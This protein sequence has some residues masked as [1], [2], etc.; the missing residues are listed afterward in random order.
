MAQQ[1]RGKL[2]LLTKSDAVDGLLDLAHGGRTVLSWSLNAESVCATWEAGTA[3]L[4]GRLA[5]ARRA[6]EAGY[7]VRFVYMPLIPVP[8]WRA[9]YAELVA[10]SLAA[11]TPSR[12]TLGGICSFPTAARVQRQ[13]FGTVE[14]LEQHWRPTGR[15][16]WRY[17]AEL[18]AEM[19]R[20]LAQE[21]RRRRP[22]LPLAL[23]LETAD[24]WEA[25][26]WPTTPVRCNCVL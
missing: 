4:D 8:D 19:Y 9:A 11:V 25:L 10:R 7:E 23:C 5:A 13:R 12:I 18:R 20:F 22:G 3:S 24:V 16:R 6:A 21:V 14:P 1:E 15:G 17:P 2:L 26:G